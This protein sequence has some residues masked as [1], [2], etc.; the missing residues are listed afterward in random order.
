MITQLEL[1]NFKSHK[2]TVLEIA[3]L[4]VLCGSNAVGKSSAIQALLLLRESYLANSEFKYLDLKSNPINVGSAK[5]AIY[6]F[7]EKNEIG[8]KINVN[9]M[10]L[11]YLFESKDSELSRTL[12]TQSTNSVHI[13][14]KAILDSINIFSKNCQFVSAA[15]LGPQPYYQK[16]DVVVGVY[17]QISVIEGRAEHFVH[18]LMEN[19]DL[20]VIKDIQNPS[21]TSGDLFYQTAAWEREISK[22]VNIN[23]VDLG[24]IGYELQYEFK[25]ESSE[26]KTNSFKSNNVGFGLSYVMPIIVAILSAP[27]GALLLI[28]NPE[29]HIH[30]NGQSK[31]A[32]LICLAC[33][34]GIQ[35]IV[36][37][38]SDHIING[39]LVQSKR[40]ENE[41]KGI[42]KK[43]V[44]IYQFLR[45]EI[46]HCSQALR[47]NIGDEGN[48]YDTPKG[49]FDQ[50]TIDREYLLDF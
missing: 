1:V 36:E 45:N 5:D 16:D 44:A 23:I 15:R 40:F 32:E 39:I 37:T 33:Q 46:E 3:P 38:H 7:A 18:Y 43:N 20:E 42:D 21:I 49:F 12:M 10:Q 14:D 24:N 30:P 2:Q 22:G 13:F 4:T 8:I 29:A 9:D 25:T 47:L 6:Q 34:A 26:G 35:I 28:E 48:L 11:S 50:F 19:K 17:N 27:P 41:S 31:L